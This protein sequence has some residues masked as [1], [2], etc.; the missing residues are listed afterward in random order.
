MTTQT[1][2]D[3]RWALFGVIPGPPAKLKITCEDCG[4]VH[5]LEKHRR[6]AEEI[7]LICHGCELEMS[8]KFDPALHPEL[9][10]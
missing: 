2:Y 7:M 9:R 1:D 10:P 8:C 4:H 6:E 3:S 5:Y